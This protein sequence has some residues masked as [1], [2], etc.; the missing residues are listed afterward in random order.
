M[1]VWAY[2]SY[3][4]YGKLIDKEGWTIEQGVFR[5]SEIIKGG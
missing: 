5:N 4:G 3:H 2:D 1:G